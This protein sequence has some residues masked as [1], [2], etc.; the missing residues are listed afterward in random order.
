MATLAGI[1]LLATGWVGPASWLVMRRRMKGLSVTDKRPLWAWGTLG[2]GTIATITIV[3][4]VSVERSSGLLGLY[5][6]AVAAEAAI[7]KWL[8]RND[9]DPSLPQ[10]FWSTAFLTL[11]PV[12]LVGKSLVE[13]PGNWLPYDIARKEF[14]PKWCAREGVADCQDLSKDEAEA[15]NAEWT[16]RR[17]AQIDALAKPGV[18]RINPTQYREMSEDLRKIARTGGLDLREVDL[19]GAFLPGMNL[20]AANM[21]SAQLTGAV[22]EAANLYKAQLQEADLNEAQLQGAILSWAQLQGTTSVFPS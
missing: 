13:K 10:G 20:V 21:Q 9:D 1:M 15:F 2:L 6:H 22:L 12:D 17:R 8:A 18:N 16:T 7:S 14:L 11:A 3:G 19:R 5:P 4:A